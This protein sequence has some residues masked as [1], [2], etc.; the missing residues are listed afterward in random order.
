MILK[1]KK[2]EFFN[3]LVNNLSNKLIFII[4]FYN[5]KY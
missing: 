4:V 3:L 2:I 5:N 1:Y